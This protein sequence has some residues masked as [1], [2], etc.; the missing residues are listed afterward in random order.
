MNAASFQPGPLAP[1]SLATIQGEKL[2]GKSVVVTFDGIPARLFYTAEAQINLLVPAEL[3]GKR[4]ASMVVTV[5]GAASA[6]RTVPLARVSPAVFRNGILNQDYSVNG[7]SSGAAPGSFVQI[8]ATGL[9]GDGAGVVAHLHD[10]EITP[11]Y[12]GAAPGFA[13]LQQVNVRVPADL[14]LMTTDLWLCAP[15]EDDRQVCSP[16]VRV[17]LQ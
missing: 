3:E 1:G 15:A 2:G 5:D 9:P 10:R 16:A 17:T 7:E 11:A 12:A 14:P 13:G 8:F 4:Q 6:P